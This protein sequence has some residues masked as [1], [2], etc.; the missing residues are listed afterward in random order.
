MTVFAHPAAS[1]RG[2]V[3]PDRV[4]KSM[5]DAGLVGIEI[6]HRD[7]DAAARDRLVAVADAWGLVRTGA[8]DYHGTGKAQSARGAPH[9]PGGVRRARGGAGAVASTGIGAPHVTTPACAS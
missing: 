7:H 5:A 6:D 3:V 1:A 9:E 4:I 2:K 8:S